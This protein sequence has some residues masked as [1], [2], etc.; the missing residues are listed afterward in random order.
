[1]RGLFFFNQRTVN[2]TVL[3]RCLEIEEDACAT[4][5]RS[6]ADYAFFDHLQWIEEKIYLD[7][8]HLQFFSSDFSY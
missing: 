1:M 6:L 4:C 8:G 2:C 7:F 3:H 5:A